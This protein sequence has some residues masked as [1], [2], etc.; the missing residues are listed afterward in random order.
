MTLRQILLILRARYKSALVLFLVVTAATLA[1]SLRAPLRYV[2]TASVLVDIR[3]SDPLT[4]MIM[5]GSLLTQVDLITSDRVARRVVKVLALD[6]DPAAKDLWPSGASSGNTIENWLAKFLRTERAPASGGTIEEFLVSLLQ[7]N[8]TVTP[9]R[10]SNVIAIAFRS[11]NPDFAAAA[12]NAYAQAYIDTV[13]EM[14]VEPARQYAAWFEGQAK[15]LRQ[16]VE[17]AHTRLAKYQQSKGIVERQEQLDF[18]SAKLR[19]LSSQLTIVQALTNDSRSKQ[20]SGAETLPEI[21]GNPVITGLKSDIARREATLQETA[22]NLGKNHPQYQRMESEIASLK[23]KLE[24]ETQNIT[25][26]YTTASMVGQSNETELKQA[27][28]LQKAKLLALKNKRYELDA[29]QRDADAATR[30]YETV[31]NRL[32]QVTLEGEATRANVSLLASAMVPREPSSPKPLRIM[33]FIALALGAA[34]GIGTVFLLELFDRRIRSTD[35]LA[36][37][38][39]VPVLGIIIRGKTH[40]RLHSAPKALLTIK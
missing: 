5:P 16:S 25:R 39:Q 40:G 31:I 1:V 17:D 38:M 11:G 21:M 2:S 26:S 14:K 12:A 32:N 8:L 10:E 22:V 15:E 6:E 13:I 4:A 37:M 30:A 28:E 27:I 29:L 23:Q 36:E 9:G 35:D 18:E 33:V 19:E 34:I 20:R 7:R 3:A 24:A